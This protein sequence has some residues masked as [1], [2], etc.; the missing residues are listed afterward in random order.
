M[1]Y[2]KLIPTVQAAMP[3]LI[4]QMNDVYPGFLDDAS[5]KL[6]PKE[7]KG[8]LG[9]NIKSEKFSPTLFWIDEN[10]D[11]RPYYDTLLFGEEKW[12]IDRAIQKRLPLI[13]RAIHTRPANP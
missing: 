13:L 5:Y 7:S 1:T 9:L 12:K 6:Y 8:I 10:L 4:S 3:I 11:V 2:N